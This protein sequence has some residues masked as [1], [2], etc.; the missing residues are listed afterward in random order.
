MY[1][2]I[3]HPTQAYEGNL[4]VDRHLNLRNFSYMFNR[5]LELVVF[6]QKVRR[7]T[8]LETYIEY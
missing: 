8:T 7:K 6:S 4:N 1:N 2:R 3:S 5:K